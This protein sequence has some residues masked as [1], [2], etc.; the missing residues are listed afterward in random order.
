MIAFHDTLRI[1]G[2]REF[3]LDF[4]TKFYDGTY[5]IVDFPFGNGDRRVGVSLLV[6]RTYPVLGIGIDEDS[7]CKS[8]PIEIYKREQ[9]WFKGQQLGAKRNLTKKGEIPSYKNKR[10]SID[11]LFS[12]L[13]RCL[14]RKVF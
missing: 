12:F 8:S 2:C 11:L 5:D 1:S 13:C 7:G 6:K 3:M 14:K 4:R 9:K 10:F